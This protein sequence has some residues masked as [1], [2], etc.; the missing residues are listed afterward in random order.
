MGEGIVSGGGIAFINA[1]EDV[2]QVTLELEGD[3]KTGAL[4]VMRALEEPLRQIAK[5]AGYE[6][7]IVLSEVQRKGVGFNALTGEYEDL[8]KTGI[9]KS[10]RI[11][12]LM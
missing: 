7:S 2:K 4:I 1:I 11:R 5:N 12:L 8:L 3:Y 6:G 10:I 9:W